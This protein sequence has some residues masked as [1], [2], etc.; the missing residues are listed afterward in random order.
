M[1]ISFPAVHRAADASTESAS[2][3][4]AGEIFIVRDPDDES[5]WQYLG[6][7]EIAARTSLSEVVSRFL[8]DCKGADG[9]IDPQHRAVARQVRDALLL[10]ARQID[11][12]LAAGR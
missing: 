11:E 4:E 3:G 9:T 6:N 10:A 8:H 7:P 12:A 5:E 1:H 2:T